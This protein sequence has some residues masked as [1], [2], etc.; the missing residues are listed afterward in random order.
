MK[1]QQPMCVWRLLTAAALLTVTA[2]AGAAEFTLVAQEF[3]KPMPDGSVVRMWGYALPGQTPS[4]PGPTLR[5]PA[6]ESLTLRITNSLPQAINGGAVPT[7]VIVPGQNTALAPVMFTDSTGRQRVRSFTHETATTQTGVYTWASPQPGSYLYHSGTQ[8]QVQVQMGL[9]GAVIVEAGPNLAY[10]GVNFDAELTLLYS[11]I[12]PALHAAVAAGGYGN[13]AAANPVTSTLN[14]SPKFF[15]VNGEPYTPGVTL[16]LATSA[17]GGRTLLR[18]LNAGLDMH[19]PVLQGLDMSLVAEDGKPYPYARNQYAAPLPPL[20]T[21][22]AVIVPPADGEYPIYDR[23]LALANNAVAPG[24]MLRLLRTGGAPI[25]QSDAYTLAEDTVFN[26]PAP[27]VLGNDFSPSGALTATLSAPPANGAVTLNLD[28]S[29]NY[30]PNPNF[31]GTDSFS[32]LAAAA[33]GASALG[34]V[35]L[36]V[37]AGNDAPTAVP[38]VATTTVN[39]AVIVDVLLNDS[40]PEGGAL[41]LAGVDNPS[42]NGGAVAIT[43]TTATYTPP[44]DFIGTDSFV[45]VVADPQGGLGTGTVT[46]T[47]QP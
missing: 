44:L 9:Y 24:G 27:G 21:L 5:V 31:N 38:D 47:V 23:R 37:T 18:L 29:F 13:P 22:D 46:V 20:K 43:G 25:A 10:P 16:P 19:V 7:S 3:D 12:D 4:V 35:T 32:Y 1:K 6:G 17:A 11:E 41:T 42:V 40:D 33:G 34:S 30:A 45:Y 8:P 15:L 26:A 28:G 36:T 2:S 14:Y 39:T